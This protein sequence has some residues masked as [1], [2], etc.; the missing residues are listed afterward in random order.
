M[1]VCEK[2]KNDVG[3]RQEVIFKQMNSLFDHIDKYPDSQNKLTWQRQM[4]KLQLEYELLSKEMRELG[5]IS[6]LRNYQILNELIAMKQFQIEYNEERKSIENNQFEK[7]YSILKDKKGNSDEEH[8]KMCREIYRRRMWVHSKSTKDPKK[9]DKMFEHVT[10]PY[11]TSEE[12]DMYGKDIKEEFIHKLNLKKK[13]ED[14][15]Q[16]KIKKKKKK[17]LKK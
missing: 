13:E 11:L 10:I 8:K 12:I 7:S 6:A 16:H 9:L 5:K 1:A 4:I 2:S 15:A 14:N 3:C 17:L